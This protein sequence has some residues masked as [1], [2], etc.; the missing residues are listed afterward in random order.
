MNFICPVCGSPLN[1]TPVLYECPNRHFYDRARSGYVNLLQR[2]RHR[3]R[4][5]DAEMVKAR[6]SFLET[7][8]YEPL[9]SELTKIICELSPTEI[10]DVGCGEGWYSCHILNELRNT[11]NEP[12]LCGVDISPDAL[13]YAA[14]RAKEMKLD[15]IS[16]WAV[17]SVSRLPFS[18]NSCDCILNLFA[19]C[20]PK[21]FGRVLRQGGYLIKTIPME[22]HL[23]ELKCAV[24]E[25]PYQNRPNLSA[26]EGFR[27]IDIQPVNKKITVSGEDLTNLFSMTPYAHK[28]STTDAAKLES[29][30][31]MDITIS[32]GILKCRK[33]NDT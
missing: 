13:R 22:K 12:F 16:A 19:P 24:Y 14:K 33:T 3:T 7:G 15:D 11:T 4:G 6:R 30:Q 21:E 26:P 10:L 17:A 2:Q 29:I 27:L 28:T 18:E 20:E 25:K 23:W 32:F 9:R 8:S 1:A 5:D 31:S